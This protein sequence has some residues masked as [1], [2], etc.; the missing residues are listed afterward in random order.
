VCH[1]MANYFHRDSEAVEDGLVAI[2]EHH[3]LPV[4]KALS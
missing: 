2:L 4:P 1:L 3:L